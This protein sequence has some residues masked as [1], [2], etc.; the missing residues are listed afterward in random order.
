ML[1]R[2]ETNSVTMAKI[3]LQRLPTRRDEFDQCVS[4]VSGKVYFCVKID[5]IWYKTEMERI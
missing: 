4:F 2:K 3:R 1:E 5:G